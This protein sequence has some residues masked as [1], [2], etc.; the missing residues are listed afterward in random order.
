MKTFNETVNQPTTKDGQLKAGLAITKLAQ[1][2]LDVTLSG[3]VTVQGKQLELAAV[4]GAALIPGFDS[5][6]DIEL[7][8][9]LELYAGGFISPIQKQIASGGTAKTVLPAGSI[10]SASEFLAGNLKTAKLDNIQIYRDITRFLVTDKTT[11]QDLVDYLRGI[12]TQLLSAELFAVYEE[13]LRK[14]A[15][16]Q[17]QFSALS[18]IGFESIQPL[19]DETFSATLALASADS[20]SQLAT[21]GYTLK[22]SSV[23]IASATIKVVFNNKPAEKLI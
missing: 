11:K 18:G 2:N 19:K 22:D 17:A 7:P 3:S 20:L 4:V 21:L 23:D 8:D 9:L 5:K 13:K 1:A 16:L 14:E 6:F 15:E 12:R 10:L